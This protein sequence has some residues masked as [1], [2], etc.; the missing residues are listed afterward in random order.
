MLQA[1][2]EQGGVLNFADVRHLIGVSTG[3]I[4]KDSKEHQLEHGVILPHRGSIHD[5]GSRLK[6]ETMIIK[7]FLQ[8]F[9]HAGV[10][11]TDLAERRSV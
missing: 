5:M 1:A 9:P 6:H 8:K 7:Q 11:Q 10:R 2:Y 4:E 3:A